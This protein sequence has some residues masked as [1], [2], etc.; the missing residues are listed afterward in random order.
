MSALVP[1]ALA[2]SL[3]KW[4]MYGT[5]NQWLAFTTGATWIIYLFIMAVMTVTPLNIGHLEPGAPAV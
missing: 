3:V 5:R 2:V 4:R 1:L